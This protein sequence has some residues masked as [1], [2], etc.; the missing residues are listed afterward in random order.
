MYSLPSLL[1]ILSFLI[2]AS[3]SVAAPLLKKDLASYDPNSAFQSALNA[4][5][6]TFWNYQYNSFSANDPTCQGAEFTSP[7]VWDIAVAG[8][9]LTDSGDQAKINAAV[10]NLLQY[11]R[12][13]G[14]FS[15]STAKDGDVYVDDNSQVLW[16]F[17]DA[18]KVTGNQDYLDVAQ[19]LMV[20]IRSQWNSQSGGV[21]WKLDGDYI[22]SISTS[23][24]ALAAVRLYEVSPD[25]DLVY[26]AQDC[27]NWLYS[28]LQD[29]ADYLFYDGLTAS[30]GVV[31]KG[32]LTYT[33][34]TALSTLAYLNKFTGSNSFIVSAVALGYAAAGGKGAFYGS[35]GYWNNQ[36]QYVHLLFAGI[37]D[38]VNIGV[39]ANSQQ[40]AAFGNFASEAKRNGAYIYTYLQLGNSGNYLSSVTSGPQSMFSKYATAFQGTGS[41]SP[42]STYFCGG[43][44]SGAVSRSFMDDSSAAQVFYEITRL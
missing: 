29:P 43:N 9:A 5:W 13:D 34:G 4:T 44:V 31:N 16:V 7:V 36:L 37:A 33:V 17:V 30:T 11:R 18:F 26:F 14:W 39:A 22:A 41:Y 19:R 32:K 2:L 8:R 42:D 40:S 28:N 12:T 25:P 20:L 24:A 15:A 27:L 6:S 3:F 23:E 21:Q 38:L 1:Q 10:Q 35:N